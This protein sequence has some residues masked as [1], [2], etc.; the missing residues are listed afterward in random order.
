ME[1]AGTPVLSAT[2]L[3]RFHNSQ[4]INLPMRVAL[5]AELAAAKGKAITDKPPSLHAEQEDK[6]LLIGHKLSSDE[7]AEAAVAPAVVGA[8][9]EADP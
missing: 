4:G 9:P 8:V 6:L 2:G 7:V 1:E 3:Q 5:V